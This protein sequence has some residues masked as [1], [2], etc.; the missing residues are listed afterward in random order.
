MMEAMETVHEAGAC[1]KVPAILREGLGWP[2]ARIAHAVTLAHNGALSPHGLSLRTFAVLATIEA[3]AARSQLEIA[4]TVGL[5]KTTLVA[6]IDDLERRGLVQRTPDPDD[7][8]ARILA[9]T[10]DGR[11]LFERAAATLRATD[12]GIF[13]QMAPEDRE[14]LKAALAALLGGP[15][16]EYLG[17]PGSCV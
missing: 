15:L 10:A 16:N 6:T 11:E 9:I 7:R 8:R 2:L 13:A 4:Q 12:A 5:D 3:G 14:R 1:S 17:R